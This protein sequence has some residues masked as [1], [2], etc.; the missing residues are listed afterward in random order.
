VVVKLPQFIYPLFFTPR[1]RG[2]T[3]I[4]G[5]GD[6]ARLGRTPLIDEVKQCVDL[7]LETFLLFPTEAAKQTNALTVDGYAPFCETIAALTQ[8]VPEA[9]V[10]LDVCLC[11]YLAH[12]HCGIV[13]DPLPRRGA[14]IDNAKTLRA[15]SE[16]A[17]A[18]AQAGAHWVAPSAMAKGQVAA[19]RAALDK[20]DER[21]V[22][23]MGYSAKF[24]STFYGPFRNACDSA[25][26][27][28]DRRSYQL[29]WDERE[30]ALDCIAADIAAGA[31]IVMVKP[32][33]AYLD[34]IALARARF[35][36]VRL[37][38]YNVSG[39]YAQVAASAKQGLCDRTRM[40]DEVISAIVR[41]GAD[42]VIS[43]HAKEIYARR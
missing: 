11:G 30:R 10:M 12:G 33:L 22:R 15:L 26:R 41:A 19:I 7:G 25:P 6:I 29:G 38:A 21:D 34:V 14:F 13:K 23:I 31:D 3:R 17:V 4:S 36:K 28:G 20:A 37:A 42:T 2:K 27:F 8:A 9:T 40:V 1:A 32:A 43:Y 24:A 39:E 35:P 16:L 18:Y 5:F